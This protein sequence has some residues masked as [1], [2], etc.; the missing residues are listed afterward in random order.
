MGHACSA[1]RPTPC[2]DWERSSILRGKEKL[3]KLRSNLGI[4]FP[5][6]VTSCSN[7]AL[8][9]KFNRFEHHVD[10][11][12]TVPPLARGISGEC[13]ASPRTIWMTLL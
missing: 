12:M 3:P 10:V 8:K 6:P 7:A 2:M 11:K 9:L 4:E 13:G 5:I 1:T